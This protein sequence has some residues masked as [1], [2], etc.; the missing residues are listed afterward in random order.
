MQGKI[1]STYLITVICRNSIEISFIFNLVP[2][3]ICDYIF[4]MYNTIKS[5]CRP[6][7]NS[8]K[9]KFR[10]ITTTHRNYGLC[11]AKI[12]PSIN[13]L[14]LLADRF[15]EFLTDKIEK[16]H[17]TFSTSLKLQHVT[18]DSPP[19]MFASFSTVTEDQFTKIILDSPTKSCSFDPWA[20]F[21][22]LEYL[23]ILI[24]PSLQRLS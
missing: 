9:Q 4:S 1:N 8:L 5:A 21:F 11:K 14:Q 24:P 22:V 17:S 2:L 12:L 15:V 23:D 3:L 13:P 10:T 18:P 6:N 7:L 16:I 20:T 19:P